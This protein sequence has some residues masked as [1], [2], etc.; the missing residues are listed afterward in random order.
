MPDSRSSADLHTGIFNQF[1]SLLTYGRRALV[2]VW[3]TS[4]LLTI[5]LAGLTL[6]AGLLPA[7]IAWVGKLLVDSVVAAIQTDAPTREVWLWLSVEALLVA[8]MAAAQTG[9]NIC[10]NLLRAQL[11]H[12]VNVMI[13]EKAQQL[14][15]AQLED[16]EFYDRLTRARRE[17]SSRPL[18]L[19]QKTFGVI[20]NG[21]SILSFSGLLLAF[22]PWAVLLLVAGGLPAFFVEAKF[23]GQAFR[24]FRWR[25]P[26]TREMMYLE[27]VLARDDY[28]K[29]VKLFGLGPK[30][31]DRYKA[32]FGK[33]FR[34]DRALTIRRGWWAFGLGLVGTATLYAAFAWVVLATVTGQLSLGE[35]TMYL[36]VFRQGQSA[37]SASLTSIN[38]MYEDY[39]Y[40]SALYEF[41]ELPVREQ[42]GGVT[43]GEAPG[44]GLEIRHLSFRYPGSEAL[45]LDSID[46]NLKPGTSLALVGEN[47][48]GKT[49]LT[50]LIAGLYQVEQGDIR[51]DGT[52][53]KDWDTRALQDRIG[54]IFQD[55]ARYQWLVG[56]NIGAGDVAAFDDQTRWHEAAEKG[57]ADAFVRALPA[58]YRTQLGRWFKDGQELSGGQWQKIALA[59]AFMRADADILIL[60][61]PTAAMDAKAEAEIFEHFQAM[62]KS[63]ILILISHRFSTVRRADRIAVMEHGR[64]IELGSHEELMTLGGRYA[65]LFELQAR[66]YR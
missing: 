43:Q 18:A 6:A 20:Q 49:T 54:V 47:G 32:I 9:L 15:L 60:D 16:A 29:E 61:E 58:G 50:K 27:S 40:L 12:R 57:L 23:A 41:L 55:F 59:R 56:H 13:L 19:V 64:I 22:S 28:T 39:L 35:M 25:S 7:G 26:E 45:A 10:N 2:L 3:A 44:A 24:L 31:L 30:L 14:E 38:G 48:S 11:G 21:I 4:P 1:G 5:A 65:Q 51:L 34:E 37:V 52:S 36:M 62:A 8:A 53:L 66:A 33:I 17:A 46:L 63:Q 42:S